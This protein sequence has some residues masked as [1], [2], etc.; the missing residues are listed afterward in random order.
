MLIRIDIFKFKS[1]VI[2]LLAERL[3]LNKSIVYLLKIKSL[4][5]R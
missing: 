3:R 2:D 5:R 1:I 4:K